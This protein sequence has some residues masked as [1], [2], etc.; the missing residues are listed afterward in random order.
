[1]EN[2]PKNIS[3]VLEILAEKFGATGTKLWEAII[4]QQFINGYFYLSV[5][6][7]ALF[8]DFFLAPRMWDL[9]LHSV[10]STNRYGDNPDCTW[11]VIYYGTLIIF[12][13][14]F[15]LNAIYRA[16]IAATCLLNPTYAALNDITS[17][18]PKKD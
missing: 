9:V 10:C 3:E 1:M 4:K 13:L 16:R 15:N 6:V 11:P 8:Y 5:P 12:T 7:A 18:L 17:M 14:A 2:I